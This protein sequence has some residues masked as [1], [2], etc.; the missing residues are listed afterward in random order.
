MSWLYPLTI[1]QF[2]GAACCRTIPA[3]Q[4]GLRFAPAHGRSSRSFLRTRQNFPGSSISGRR[5]EW[6]RR[7]I[8]RADGLMP[9]A[10]AVTE[11]RLEIPNWIL[12]DTLILFVTGIIKRS[13]PL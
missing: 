11:L 10:E 5:L 1:C 12:A 7:L 3:R 2:H 8:N 4:V 9:P 6:R 13:N